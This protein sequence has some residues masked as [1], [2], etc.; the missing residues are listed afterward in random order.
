M[1]KEIQKSSSKY[2]APACFAAIA[3]A[4]YWFW[5][6]PCRAALGY[7]EEMLLFQTTSPYLDALA[8]RPAGISVY[9]GEFLT[10][11]FNNFWIGAAVMTALL[12]LFLYLTLTVIRNFF[13]EI[14]PSVALPISLL[15]LAALWL[16]LGNPDVTLCFVVALIL[17]MGAVIVFVS[18]CPDNGVTGRYLHM[19]ALTAFLYWLAGPLAVIFTLLVIFNMGKDPSA[20]LTHKVFFSSLALI[21]LAVNFLMW[22]PSLPYPAAYQ[23]IGIGFLLRPDVLEAGQV[24]VTGLCVLLPVIALIAQRLPRKV[25]VP[26]LV[27]LVAVAAVVFFSRCYDSATY[28]LIDYDYMVRANDWD[29]IIRY[30]DRHDPD[31]RLGAS[32]TNLALGMTGQLDA[33][34]FDYFQ[35]GPEGLLPSFSKEA[36]SSWTTGEIFFQ[37]GMVNSAQRFYFEGM[38]AIPNYN[39]SA[40]AVKRL[41]E[42][43]I[44]RGDYRLAEKY[45]KILENTTFYRKWA[46]RNLELI[47]NPESVDSHP[48]YG[49]L[50]KRMVDEDYLFS[51]M[52]L[53]KTL[54][55]LFLKD[56]ANNLARQY[57]ILYPLLQRDLNTFGEYMG[58]ITKSYPQYNPP[59]AQQ[60]IAFMSMKNGQPMPQGMVSPVVEQ[61]LR[62]FAQAWTSKNPDLIA[63][64]RHTLFYYLLSDK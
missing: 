16:F 8:G 12:I 5:A 7:R 33:R 56:P 27:C 14:K 10:Q 20:S 34:A 44:I 48:L 35:H 54:G 31:S 17:A 24:V 19:L 40:R 37:L 52:E 51:E 28:R 23:L 13:P 30:S 2:I 45:L 26:T 22:M 58:V 50:R 21:W 18:S 38:E 11:T 49:Q 55:Q 47:M 61:S 60:A 32:A 43:A 63:Q 15:P 41:A 59:L 29:A 62:G 46:K 36:I 57:M 3:A 64:H 1:T 6:F 53:D 42:T 9:I 4:L 25:M 39:K